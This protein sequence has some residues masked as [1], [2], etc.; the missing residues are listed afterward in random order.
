MEIW[1]LTHNSLGMHI[2]DVLFIILAAVMIVLALVHHSNQTRRE[3]NNT[4][5][6]EGLRQQPEGSP[7][8]EMQAEKSVQEVE[9]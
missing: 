1:N 9:V 7:V 5:E 4:K 3:K 6:L 8:T 2:F